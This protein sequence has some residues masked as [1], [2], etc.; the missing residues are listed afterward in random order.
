MGETQEGSQGCLTLQ[1]S[2]DKEYKF[3]RVKTFTYLLV[4]IEEKR[5]GKYYIQA[6]ITKENRNYG[7]LMTLMKIKCV[8]KNMQMTVYATIFRSAVTSSSK[9]WILNRTEKDRLQRCE[10]KC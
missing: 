6:I 4:E 7:M 3:K 2:S 5:L 8:C 10:I 1:A 9:A